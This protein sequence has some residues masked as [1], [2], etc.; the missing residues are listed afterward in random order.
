MNHMILFYGHERDVRA[1][2]GGCP[3][4]TICQLRS[5][6]GGLVAWAETTEKAVGLMG[7]R[8]ENE[9]SRSG[10]IEKWYPQAVAAMSPADFELFGRQYLRPGKPEPDK[11]GD[12]EMD[13]V[14]GPSDD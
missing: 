12:Y 7:K 4:G 5:I 6:P 1:C 11:T 8:L 2:V 14:L 13:L 10:G 9:F 3:E